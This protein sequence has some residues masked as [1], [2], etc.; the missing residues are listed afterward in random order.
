MS[1]PYVEFVLEGASW[2]WGAGEGDLGL[3]SG[4]PGSELSPRP[5]CTWSLFSVIFKG[6]AAFWESPPSCS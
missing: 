3:G 5:S 2:V 1:I 4:L 6:P